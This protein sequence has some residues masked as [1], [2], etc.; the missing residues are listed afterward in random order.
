[1][2]TFLRHTGAYL[3]ACLASWLLLGL[4]FWISIGIAWFTSPLAPYTWAHLVAGNLLAGLILY[5]FGFHELAR[6]LRP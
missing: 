3:V 1:M 2:A 4:P 6:R 5:A